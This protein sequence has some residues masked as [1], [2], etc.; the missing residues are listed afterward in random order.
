M[1]LMSQIA[2]AFAPVAG[3]C[4]IGA[5][6]SRMGLRPSLGAMAPLASDLAVPCLVFTTLARTP[7][8]AGTIGLLAAASCACVVLSALV[9][10]FVLIPCR[11]QLRVYLGPLTFPNTGSVGLPLSAALYGPLGLTYAT[12]FYAVSSVL[13]GVFGQALA[14]GTANLRTVFSLPLFHAAWLGMAAGILRD[15][16]PGPLAQAVLGATGLAGQLALPL[17]LLMLGASLTELAAPRLRRAAILG[18]TRLL[19]GG[20]AGCVVCWLFALSGVEGGVFVL[21]AAMPVGV[22]SYLYAQRWDA[23]P[24]EVAGLVVCSTLEAFCLVPAVIGL[25]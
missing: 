2:A 5:A 3:L 21:Q 11:L 25:G 15:R 4:A 18:L 12:V 9:A 17:M 1:L 6:W 20:A 14:A 22:N 23:Q 24:V 19:I 13:N 16:G 8:P 7:V 10:T